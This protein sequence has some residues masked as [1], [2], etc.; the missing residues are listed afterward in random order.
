MNL[1]EISIDIEHV[2]IEAVDFTAKSE[3]VITVTSTLESA[4]CDSCG[5]EIK[6]FHSFGHEIRL[7]RLPIL[8]KSTYIRIKPKR[9]RCSCCHG[10]PTTAQKLDWYDP[11]SPHTKGY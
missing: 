9:Y 8:G 7:R 11:R 1:F 3:I 10:G 2:K 5:Q 4:Y 6:E